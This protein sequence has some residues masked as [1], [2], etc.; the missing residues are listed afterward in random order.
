MSKRYREALVDVATSARG[1]VSG[2]S[3]DS[4]GGRVDNGGGV[5][6]E[7]TTAVSDGG[8]GGGAVASLA[9]PVATIEQVAATSEQMVTAESSSVEVRP[10]RRRT[11][12]GPA[13]AHEPL[14]FTWRDRRYTV[15]HVL[16][17]W[18]EE[19]GWWRRP[20]G[21]PIRIEQSDL[22]RVEATHATG[23]M[24]EQSGVYELS[25]RGESWRLDRV[26]D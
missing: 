18:R 10:S 11:G 2:E 5:R 13:D 19:S 6:A 1:A 12:N 22:W 21:E 23:T 15:V 24:G 20:D 7:G 26:W 14:A 16:G 4:G 9:R 17:H 8:R 25:H 3:D